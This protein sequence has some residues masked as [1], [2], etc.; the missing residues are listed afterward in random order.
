M[1]LQVFWESASADSFPVFDTSPA[2]AF[3]QLR[4]LFYSVK[5]KTLIGL[6][7]ATATDYELNVGGRRTFVLKK[8]WFDG[9]VIDVSATSALVTPGFVTPD[10]VLGP[11]VVA[12]DQGLVIRT[13]PSSGGS[14]DA[15]ITDDQGDSYYESSDVYPMDVLTRPVVCSAELFSTTHVG[16]F[17]AVSNAAYVLGT[18]TDHVI[19]NPGLLSRLSFA[20][21]PNG[22]YN[23]P[24]DILYIDRKT[25]AITYSFASTLNNTGDVD[26]NVS[27]IIRVFSAASA[28]WTLKF[29]AH[30]PSGDN[31]TAYDPVNKILYSTKRAGG[32]I[33]ASLLKRAPLTVA[34]PTLVSVT[35]LRFPGATTVSTLI[36]DSLGSVMS[37]QLVQWTLTSQNS[38]GALLSAYASTNT[39]GIATMTYIAPPYASGASL[40]ETVTVKV[41]TI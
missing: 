28:P 13:R 8:L 6:F 7:V 30:L 39:S 27:S 22:T 26:P 25:I 12:T 32:T 18:A 2:T 1:S 15:A 9:T 20:S 3:G 5:T 17:L 40:T 10:A 33:H 23:R 29:E 14:E 16:L 37:G 19:E 31:V 24:R 21:N 4:K 34:T 41:A 38:G 11:K 35:T 36:K